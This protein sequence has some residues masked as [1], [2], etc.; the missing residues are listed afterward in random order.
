MFLDIDL[1]MKQIS[2]TNTRVANHNLHILE[3]IFIWITLQLENLSSTLYHGQ[4]RFRD[5]DRFEFWLPIAI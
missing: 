1:T 3:I 4:C 2:F 5:L